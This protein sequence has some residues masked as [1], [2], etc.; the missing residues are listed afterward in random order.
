MS[1]IVVAATGSDSNHGFD[2]GDAVQTLTRALQ[3]SKQPRVAVN[4]NLFP[5]CCAKPT[6]R[7]GWALLSNRCRTRI[8]E[9]IQAAISWG[10]FVAECENCGATWF[11]F[12]MVQ[13]GSNW[14][15]GRA[16][17][18]KVATMA[19]KALRAALRVRS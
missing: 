19:P 14:I 3:L 7:N 4:G 9:R 11:P 12:E 18:F 16:V 15:N 13:S 6:P 8:V 10:C 2:Q 17:E 5:D 1:D